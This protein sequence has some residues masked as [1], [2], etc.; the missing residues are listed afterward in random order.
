MNNTE[1]NLKQETLIIKMLSAMVDRFK[2]DGSSIEVWNG[3]DKLLSAVG[4]SLNGSNK[5]VQER[6][7]YAAL[8]A[9]RV[10]KDTNKALNVL[11]STIP[12]NGIE[13]FAL[14]AVHKACSDSRRFKHAEKKNKI[15]YGVV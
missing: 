4:V 13:D 12:S 7:V 2:K 8:Q 5:V 9:E 10:L 14:N 1:L 15:S 3:N 11:L 6:V